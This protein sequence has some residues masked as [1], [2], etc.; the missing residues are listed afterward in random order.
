MLACST[1]V[2]RRR[3]PTVSSAAE[4]GAS[5]PSLEAQTEVRRRPSCSTKP[6]TRLPRDPRPGQQASSAEIVE[7]ARG[8]AAREEGERSS[9]PQAKADDRAGGQPRPGT[10]CAARS[11]TVALDRCP[12]DHFPRDRELSSGG[13]PGRCSTSWRPR[14]R[15]P[16]DG[17]T[18]MSE[19]STESPRPYA[20]AV[21]HDIAQ[22][23]VGRLDAW[24]DAAAMRR[25]CD[26]SRTRAFAR[27]LGSPNT[28]RPSRSPTS[29]IGHLR[30]KRRTVPTTLGQVDISSEITGRE[31]AAWACL[32]EIRRRV[33]EQAARPRSE[34]SRRR[35]DLTSAVPL[36]DQP[37]RDLRPPRLRH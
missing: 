12:A 21:F 34:N 3:S 8:T 30:A 1:S 25:R 26:G 31:R 7:E 4:K 28:P 23:C 24:S 16:G 13:S 5:R 37:A 35:R 33:F 29:I 19:N 22:R 17:V 15:P 18:R 32:P 6:A 9:S 14:S 11:P 10:S 36:S 27:L 20:K 2:G